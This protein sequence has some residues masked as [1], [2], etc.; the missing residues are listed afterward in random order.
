L[1]EQEDTMAKLQ[2]LLQVSFSTKHAAQAL[3]TEVPAMRSR[4]NIN[5]HAGDMS[6]NGDDAQALADLLEQRL[7]HR[8]ASLKRASK[9]LPASMPSTPE[10]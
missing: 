4:F 9:A 7:R 1:F 3:K 10:G 6:V 2:Q 5:T 8:L